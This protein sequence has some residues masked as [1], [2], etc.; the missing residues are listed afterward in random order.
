MV[1]I[2][3]ETIAYDIKRLTQLHTLDLSSNFIGN[4]QSYDNGDP[5]I[6]QALQ[7]HTQLKTLKLVDNWLNDEEI[8]EARAT[9]V[10][11]THIEYY[12]NFYP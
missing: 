9:Y 10:G 2:L 4:V 5:G 3:T 1:D 8:A 12:P 7:D 11:N 6:L